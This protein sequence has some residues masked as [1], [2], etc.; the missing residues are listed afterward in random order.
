MT[1]SALD[2]VIKIIVFIHDFLK[3]NNFSSGFYAIKEK[4]SRN[5]SLYWS[6]LR[7]PKIY[8]KIILAHSFIKIIAI[9]VS[10]FLKNNFVI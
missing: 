4:L 2:Y 3:S 9:E 10:A 1:S 8:Q 6:C 5:L 7:I